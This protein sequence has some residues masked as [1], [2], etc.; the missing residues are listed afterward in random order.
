MSSVSSSS[1]SARAPNNQS[2]NFIDLPSEVS[3]ANL[4]PEVIEEIYRRAISKPQDAAI[5]SLVNK[6]LNKIACPWRALALNKNY[7][8]INNLSWQE[9]SQLVEFILKSIDKQKITYKL[10]EIK[11]LLMRAEITIEVLHPITLLV[12][13][14]QIKIAEEAIDKITE[15]FYKYATLAFLAK[16]LS[17]AGHFDKAELIIDKIT[18]E[19]FKYTPLAFLAK[20]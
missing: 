9:T 1:S 15:E 11:D 10:E 12:Q 2:I 6:K 19:V 18:D 5:I 20:E 7:N 13:L 14:N 17:K 4:P 16:E 8:S 3:E